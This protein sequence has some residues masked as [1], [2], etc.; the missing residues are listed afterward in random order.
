MGL[1]TKIANLGRLREITTVF[2]G[3]QITWRTG[4]VNEFT[5][6]KIGQ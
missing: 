4:Y 6:H 2:H 5:K 1:E 3:G